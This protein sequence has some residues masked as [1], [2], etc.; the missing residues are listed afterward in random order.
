MHGTENFKIKRQMVTYGDYSSIADNGQ[1]FS[2]YF[3]VFW[4][5]EIVMYLFQHKQAKTHQEL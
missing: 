3:V 2:R 1:N 5:F 4:Y